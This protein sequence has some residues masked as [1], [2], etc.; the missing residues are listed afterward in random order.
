MRTLH[1]RLIRIITYERRTVAVWLKNKRIFGEWTSKTESKRKRKKKEIITY[2][3]TF[4]GFNWSYCGVAEVI[5]CAINPE[6][7]CKRA[8]FRC[9]FAYPSLD[10]DF[11]F[12]FFIHSRTMPHY[13]LSACHHTIHHGNQCMHGIWVLVD[14]NWIKMKNKIKRCSSIRGPSN[15]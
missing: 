13:F 5:Q 6:F 12:S 7:Q 15:G 3:F 2:A 1:T 14:L 9:W 11:I 8:F 4:I 10:S